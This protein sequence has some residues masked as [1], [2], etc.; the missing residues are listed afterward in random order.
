[1]GLSN[2]L[3][4]ETGS[5]FPCYNPH[6]FLQPEVLRLYFPSAGTLSCMVCLAP[7]LFF[8]VFIHTW[9]WDCPVRQPLPGCVTS[10]PQ[11]PVSAPPTGLDECFFFNSLVVRLPHNLIFWQFWLFFVL[12]LIVI[13]L[14]GCGRRWSIST[15]ASILARIPKMEAIRSFKHEYII[16]G[17]RQTITYLTSH[18]LMTIKMLRNFTI[19]YNNN[20]SRNRVHTKFRE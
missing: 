8:P 13:F 1:M 12:K 6:R 15:Y 11:L 16:P 7:Q 3:S 20:K 4:W 2:G 10:S 9:M 17:H 19:S 14:F 18:L 5:F